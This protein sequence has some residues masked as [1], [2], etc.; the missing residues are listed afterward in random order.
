MARTALRAH[1]TLDSRQTGRT[2]LGEE[3][4]GGVGGHGQTPARPGVTPR[5]RCYLS[6]RTSPDWGRP[7]QVRPAA[8][9]APGSAGAEGRG[10][11]WSLGSRAQT[12]RR[13]TVGGQ[14][15]RPRLQH[16][17]PSKVGREGPG[18]GRGRAEH[19]PFTGL[20]GRGTGRKRLLDYHRRPGGRLTALSPSLPTSWLILGPALPSGF[21]QDRR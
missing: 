9:S 5:R 4:V 6:S 19:A 8:V 7:S 20:R 1:G 16:M 18:K 17:T 12:G 2:V 13:L 14:T 21:S 15:R 10:A 11:E 3:P